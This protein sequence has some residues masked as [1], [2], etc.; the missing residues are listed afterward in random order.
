MPSA[1][2]PDVL[3]RAMR[4]SF[5][6]RFRGVY[7][8]QLREISTRLP[9]NLLQLLKQHRVLRL[10]TDRMDIDVTDDTLLIDDENSTLRETFPTKH[11]I[12]ECR[13]AVGK[14]V[15]EQ[16]IRNIAQRFCPRF[17]HRNVIDAHAQ[18][19]GIVPRELGKIFL[20]RRH[21]D[22]SNG[23]EGQWVE[24]QNNVL[25]PTKVRELHVGVQM[26]PQCEIRSFLTDLGCTYIFRHNISWSISIRTRLYINN[27]CVN[28]P[29]FSPGA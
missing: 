4:H 5:R 24:R 15:T 22:R 19:L 28:K 13:Q 3:T 8:I 10:I 9:L 7:G 23:G 16:R 2:A 20:V 17:D 11:T 26:R 27:R 12:F 6:S 21:L 14:E 1:Y 25:L 29:A 18:N